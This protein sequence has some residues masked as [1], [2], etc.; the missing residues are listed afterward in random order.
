[1]RRLFALI[2][3]ISIWFNFAPPAKAIGAGLVPCS[4]SPAFKELAAKARATT[5]TT[6]GQDRFQRYADGGA[7]C[8]PEGYPHLIVDGNLAHAGDF[9]IPSILF[10]YLAGWIGW[11]GRSYIRAVKKLPGASPESK[12]VIIDVPLAI[13]CGFLEGPTWPLLALKE[14]QT[15]EL[16][17]RDEEIPVSPR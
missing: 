2:L 7:L 9:L 12:E 1:M 10:L 15:G 17:A 16:I 4:E 6:K 5:D 3:A 13:R 14:F 8:G 11:A